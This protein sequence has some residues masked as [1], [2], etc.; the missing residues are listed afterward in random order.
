MESSSLEEKVK[1]KPS[2]SHFVHGGIF[3]LG[4]K[5][6]WPGTDPDSRLLKERVEGS[7]AEGICQDCILTVNRGN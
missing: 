5:E 3:P 6:N 4:W 2:G 7:L 1:R